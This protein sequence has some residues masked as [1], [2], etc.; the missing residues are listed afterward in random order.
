MQWFSSSVLIIALTAQIDGGSRVG[1]CGRTGAGTRRLLLILDI[2]RFVIVLI[3]GKSS[4]MVA[5]F[6][7]VEIISGLIMIDGI[8]TK[9]VPL[10]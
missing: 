10:D 8:D 6:R 3:L 1:V 4:I 7:I 5:L 2:T 9:R